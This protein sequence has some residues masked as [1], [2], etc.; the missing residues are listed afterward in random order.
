MCRLCS[1]LCWRDAWLSDALWL[2]L[3][4]AALACSV[5]ALCRKCRSFLLSYLCAFRCHM[6]QSFMSR[7]EAEVQE[8]EMAPSRSS[9]SRSSAQDETGL[10]TRET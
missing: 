5:A 4:C 9:P 8:K 10:M 6:P 1:R 3:R 2:W 7:L